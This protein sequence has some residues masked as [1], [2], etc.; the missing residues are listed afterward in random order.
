MCVNISSLR[1]PKP[2]SSFKSIGY[3]PL[4]PHQ[5][6]LCIFYANFYEFKRKVVSKTAEQ[7][8]KSLLKYC[9]TNILRYKR[10]RVRVR[11]KERDPT[12]REREREIRKRERDPK[13]RERK[14][15]RER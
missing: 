4:P 1:L 7:L 2:S 15:E 12:E 9:N 8:Q 14:R 6:I 5:T 13:E 11:V 10:G 3:L